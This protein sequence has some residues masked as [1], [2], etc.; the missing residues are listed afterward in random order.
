MTNRN[1]HR[2]APQTVRELT[3][4]IGERIYVRFEQL[5]IDCTV[6]DAKNSWG[7]V[8]LLIQPV[9]G[10]GQQW[11]EMGRIN[12]YPAGTESMREAQEAAREQARRAEHLRAEDRRLYPA[13]YQNEGG[14]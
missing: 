13:D 9:T 12:R 4:A 3:P 5:T 7:Q 1:T 11:V 10:T 8:R 14:Y 6:V 2:T